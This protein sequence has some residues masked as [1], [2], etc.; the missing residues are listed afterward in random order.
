VYESVEALAYELEAAGRRVTG[1][2]RD[3]M[4]SA[5]QRG[6]ARLGAT[7]AGERVG[8]W[9]RSAGGLASQVPLLSWQADLVAARHGVDRLVCQVQQLPVTDLRAGLV[10]IQLV[11]ALD[12]VRRER[13]AIRAATALVNPSSVATSTLMLTA[14]R[15]GHVDRTR[16]LLVR[17]AHSLAGRQRGGVEERFVAAHV[18]ARAYLAGGKPEHSLRFAVDAAQLARRAVDELA[19]SVDPVPTAR[20]RLR[21]GAGTGVLGALTTAKQVAADLLAPTY[22]QFP[23]AEQWRRRCGAALVTAA[24]AHLTLGQPDMA[25]DAAAAAVRLGQSMGYVPQAAALPASG[26]S[27]RRRQDLLRLVQGVDRREYTG[28]SNGDG[29]TVLNLT[30]LQAKKTVGLVRRRKRP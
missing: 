25:L 15:L 24:W 20:Q 7:A 26:L 3:T 28:V 13:L 18:L 30:A 16:T 29:G 4:T 27:V 6:M 21:V 12:N 8:E 10:A 11:E 23:P 17:R 5:Y 22:E 2:S 9:V 14:G 19:G 1:T